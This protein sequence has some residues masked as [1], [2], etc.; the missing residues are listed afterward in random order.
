MPSVVKAFCIQIKI[1][2]GVKTHFDAGDFNDVIVGQR[3]S[4]VADFAVIHHGAFVL[5][6]G[7][8]HDQEVALGSAR[9][10]GHL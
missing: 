9:D 6:A 2:T 1:L 3:V 4:L 10:S 8:D 5:F 7:I